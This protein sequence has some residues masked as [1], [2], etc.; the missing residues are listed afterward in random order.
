MGQRNIEQFKAQ[1]AALD[2]VLDQEVLDDID[3]I[4]PPGGVTVPYYLDDAF[5]D[6]RPLSHRW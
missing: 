1:L 4:V 3:R 6:F 5:A 2:L